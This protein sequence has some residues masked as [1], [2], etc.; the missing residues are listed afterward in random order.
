MYVSSFP[1]ICICTDNRSGIG[2]KSE[3]QKHGIA[4]VVD[5]PVEE[6]ISDHPFLATFW[7][8]KDRGLSLGDMEMVTPDCDWTAGVGCDFPSFHRHEDEEVRPWLKRT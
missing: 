7:K 2:P 1:L 3:L 5:L 6:N 8:D 4:Q